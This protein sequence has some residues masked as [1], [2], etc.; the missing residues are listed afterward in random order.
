MIHLK[1]YRDAIILVAMLFLTQITIAQSQFRFQHFSTKDGLADDFVLSVKQDSLGYIWAQYYGGI[2]RFDGHS[3]KVYRHDADDPRRASLNF[4]I[5]RLALDKSGN[6]W[7]TQHHHKPPFTI[8]RYDRKLDGFRKFTAD[9]DLEATNQYR[10]DDDGR[11]LWL[12]MREGKGLQSLDLETGERTTYLNPSPNTDFHKQQNTIFDTEDMGSS[13]LVATERGLWSCDKT[14]KTF[15]RPVCNAKDSSFLYNTPIFYVGPKDNFWIG[16]QGGMLK[17]GPDFS[18]LKRIDFP[19]NFYVSSFSFA[20][21]G[22]IWFGTWNDGLCRVD[23]AD[24]SFTHVRN[25]PGDPHSLNS[26]SVN[27]VLV[28]RDNNVWVANAKGIS[29]LLPQTMKFRNIDMEVGGFTIYNANGKDVLIISK[30]NQATLLKDIFMASIDSGHLDDLRFQG[31][32]SVK[33][34]DFP[35]FYKGKNHFWTSTRAN[36]SGIYRLP[37]NPTSGMIERGTPLQFRHDPDNP[38]TISSDQVGG[39]W[40]DSNGNLWIGNEGLCKINL[41]FPYGEKGSVTKYK[42]SPTDSNAIGIHRPALIYPEDETSVWL[43]GPEGIELFH[44]NTQQVDRIFKNRETARTIYKSSDGTVFLGTVKGLYKATKQKGKYQFGSNPIWSKAEVTAIQ[45]D[46][47]GRL[48]LYSR[49]GPVCYDPKENIA[50]EFNESDGVSHVK[51]IERGYLQQTSKG[52]MI[53]ADPSG[54][55]VFDPLTL[56]ID[57]QSVKPVLTS[58][59]VNNYTPNVGMQKNETNDF[60]TSKDI[61]VLDELIIDYQHNNFA[62]AFSTMEM[63]APE[64]NLYRHKLEGYDN[65]WIETDF[66]DRTATYTNL[67]AGEYTFRVMASNH[68]GI[69]SDVQTILKIKVLPPPWKSAWAYTGYGLIFLGLLY[70][71]RKNIV[72]RERLKSN[73]KLAQV[74]Q[75][76]EHFELEKAKEVDKVKSTFFANISHEFR[77]PLTLIKG[78]VQELMEEFADHPKV[79]DRLKLVERN[80]DLVLKLI[81]QLLDLAKLESGTLSVEKTENDLNVF[82]SVVTNSFSS[83]AFQKNI[84]LKSELPQ[85]RVLV[86]FDKGKVETILINLINNAIKFTPPGGSVTVQ[87]KIEVLQDSTPPDSV[88]TPLR[89]RGAGGEVGEV[90]I[91]VSDTGIGIDK[92]QHEKVFERFHQVSEAHKEVGTGIGLS[93]V[94]E[95]VAL[96]NGTLSLKSEPGKGSEFTVTLP[97]EVIRLMTETEELGKF[98]ELQVPEEFT[99]KENGHEPFDNKP[100]ILV[101]EDNTDL[102]KFIIGSLGNEF[103]FLEGADGKQGLEIALDETPDLIISDVMMPEMDGIMM[104]GRI[105]SDTRTSHI[106]L[107]LLTAKTSDESKLSGLETGADDYLTKPFNKNELLLKVRN[108]IALRVK[109]REKIKLEL[110]KESPNVEVQSAD[111][112]F[113]LKVR[114]AIL[115]RLSDEQLSV[116]SLAEEIGLSRSQLF[117]KI[118]ALTGVSV[119]ELIRT[120]R[121]QKAAQLLEQNWAPVTQVAYEVG[122]S[123]LSYFSKAF[124]EKYGVL[125]SEYGAKTL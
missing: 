54:L 96:M 124:K 68:H 7:V 48:W 63:S 29:K 41:S 2:S 82:L 66:R 122:Y 118:S 77:T 105:K 81:N 98:E 1:K 10:T 114:E 60:Y 83:L 44:H 33:S 109:L 78:P 86:N 59:K 75:E 8:A 84:S 95:L 17:L 21:D 100:R 74:E 16:V 15:S 39:M 3:F 93:L 4:L 106:P 121:L 61:S 88:G 28:D 57:R 6:L 46:R 110:L 36:G 87:T 70:A 62:I 52:L 117:R 9:L 26:N 50:I 35:W 24:G 64:K 65:D 99:L 79:K 102:R 51:A 69:W 90:V 91:T 13:I 5:G 45:E 38:N 40:E 14:T 18:I 20:K 73:L 80:A 56:T 89:R 103:H 76:K 31:L 111:E 23:P 94:K 116:E 32:L 120:F 107:I 49:I 11:T 12:N 115:S 112:K 113:L 34:A 55:S 67:D 27:D 47:L 72:Q 43:H 108:N 37:I 19:P 119:N 42:Y 30:D 71:A 58:L 97:V 123:N 125:P 53:L 22:I 104:T 101:V 25:V 92:D 85:Q